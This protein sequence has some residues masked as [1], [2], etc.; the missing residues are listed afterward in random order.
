MCEV[1]RTVKSRFENLDWMKWSLFSF[2]FQLYLSPALSGTFSLSLFLFP[3][4]HPFGRNVWRFFSIREQLN[5]DR[6]LISMKFDAGQMSHKEE[7]L[8]VDI[9]NHA[10]KLSQE[11]FELH[12]NA[13]ERERCDLS[14]DES[15]TSDRWLISRLLELS[16]LSVW[17]LREP[18]RRERE[19]ISGMR[20]W[21]Y[22]T[23]YYARRDVVWESLSDSCVVCFCATSCTHSPCA[24][25]DRFALF[26]GA[27]AVRSPCTRKSWQRVIDTHFSLSRLAEL[28]HEVQVS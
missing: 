16:T 17:V 3:L 2:H 1:E 19:M 26:F 8:T 18:K 23:R 22:F 21:C 13:S 4:S 28:V 25:L 14:D 27:A 24:V 5:C 11:S 12:A 6:I 7:K 15:T 9:E 10:E 20:K